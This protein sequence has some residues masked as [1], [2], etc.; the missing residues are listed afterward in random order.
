MSHEHHANGL[1]IISLSSD[2]EIL[3]ESFILSSDQL[4]A[5]AA[6]ALT[7][8]AWFVAYLDYRVM[9]GTCRTDGHCEYYKEYS[10]ETLNPKY[11]QRV[12]I[13]NQQEE[14]LLWR[15]ANG[16]QGRIRRDSDGNGTHVVVTHQVLFGTRIDPHFQGDSYMK[17]TEDRGTSLIL[18]RMD[19]KVN[20]R[21]R[22]CIQT[23]NY[24]D[25]HKETGQAGYVDSR[26]VSFTDGQ[27]DLE[28][29]NA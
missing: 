16:L 1:R 7:V 13:F 2:V 3:N 5:A 17:I 26:F 9:I 22:I 11:V 18:P 15:T 23:Y 27:N 20:K 24:I 21:D 6:D 10:E 8:P 29:R 19:V 12:R 28:R 14:L 25:Y 4:Q